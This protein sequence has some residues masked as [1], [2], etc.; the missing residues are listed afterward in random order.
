MEQVSEPSHLPTSA[1]FSSPQELEIVL[2]EVQL[3]YHAHSS[4][5]CAGV[6]VLFCACQRPLIYVRVL[7]SKV[8]R[9]SVA[10]KFSSAD[11]ATLEG[12]S[13]SFNTVLGIQGSFAATPL[14][15][16]PLTG[17]FVCL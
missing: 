17:V 7:S 3:V 16:T 8:T 9:V 4:N 11:Q 14:K 13:I 1:P 10:T 6:G 15:V 2:E 5:R 12:N